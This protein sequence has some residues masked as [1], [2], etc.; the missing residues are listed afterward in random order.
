[1]LHW[2]SASG[3][4]GELFGRD[5]GYGRNLPPHVTSAAA[6][7]MLVRNSLVFD[8]ADT[9]QLTLGPRADWW[10]GSRV[11]AAPTRWGVID[12]AFRRT[13]D[14]VDWTW[15]SVPVWTALS[16]PAGTRLAQA[17]AAP[18]V[19]DAAMRTVLAPPGTA[20]LGVAVVRTP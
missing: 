10:R 15:T 4:A 8:D 18:F 3:G 13:G 17:P 7:V 19:A 14:T 9:L 12:V 6:L 11:H 1:M 20:H 16:L 2:R 5:G